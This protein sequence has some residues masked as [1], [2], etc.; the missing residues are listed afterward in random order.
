MVFA[1]F[2]VTKMAQFSCPIRLFVV[3]Q[4]AEQ[5]VGINSMTNGI[6]NRAC[7]YLVVRSSHNASKEGETANKQPLCAGRTQPDPPR[8]VHRQIRTFTRFREKAITVDR[9]PTL[10]DFAI[11]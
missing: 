1:A 7:S 11:I 3:V 4:G 5:V 10:V 2:P 8:D 9:S 6:T